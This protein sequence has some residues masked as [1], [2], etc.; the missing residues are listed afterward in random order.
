MFTVFGFYKF[1]KG[2]SLKKNKELLQ[3]KIIKNNIRGTII[4][5]PEGING[6]IAGKSRDINKIIKTLKKVCRFKNFDS[7]NVSKCDFQPFHKEKIKIR[8]EVVPLNL[9]V[10][11]KNKRMNKYVSNKSW[12]KLILNKET[13]VIDVRKPFEHGV[14][15][16][17]SAINPKIQ[18]FRDFPKFLKKI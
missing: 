2:N 7:K 9:K 3:R 4:L 16:F 11:K 15:T 8:K 17:K 5:S 6:T 1:N 18:N 10:N 12:N 13:L 14:G